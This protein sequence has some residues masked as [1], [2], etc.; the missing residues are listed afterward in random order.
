MVTIVGIV[1][2]VVLVVSLAL[3]DAGAETLGAIGSI[4]GA[5]FIGLGVLS[6][7]IH[8]R[9]SAQDNGE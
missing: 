1:A 5:V 2:A 4:T 9:R 8:A 3:I 6:Q 7:W